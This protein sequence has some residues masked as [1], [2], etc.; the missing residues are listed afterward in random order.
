MH[1]NG[2]KIIQNSS[3]EESKNNLMHLE[4]QDNTLQRSLQSFQVNYCISLRNSGMYKQINKQTIWLNSLTEPENTEF[5]LV[6]VGAYQISP[7][8]NPFVRNQMSNH[9]L[10]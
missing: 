10:L 1:K 7:E 6:G 9:I 8:I 5:T 3:A 2:Q 4:H